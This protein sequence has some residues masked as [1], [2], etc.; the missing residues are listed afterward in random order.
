MSSS[1][2]NS[3]RKKSTT[4]M[5]P[6]LTLGE[7][8]ISPGIVC[9]RIEYLHIYVCAAVIRVGFRAADWR[10][11]GNPEAG[12]PE[13]ENRPPRRQ[14]FAKV[15][16]TSW[17]WRLFSK[18]NPI[19]FS[20]SGDTAGARIDRRKMLSRMA[21]ARTGSVGHRRDVFSGTLR[22]CAFQW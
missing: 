21:A 13:G 14:R 11:S 8:G 19:R 1:N 5:K 18:G 3:P 15:S 6:W 16:A 9:I 7:T 20:S 4:I 10:C 12:S 17:S 2:T 22:T